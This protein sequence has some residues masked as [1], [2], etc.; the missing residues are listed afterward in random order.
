M[1]KKFGIIL[2]ILLC[3]ALVFTF[4][5][6]GN[7]GNTGNSGSNEDKNGDKPAI[8]GV[9]AAQVT[10]M[11]SSIS[12]YLDKWLL[13]N[14]QEQVK[15][16][17]DLLEAALNKVK[18]D[19][20]TFTDKDM[21]DITPTIQVSFNETTKK[22]TVVLSWNKNA[23][24]KTFEKEA[25]TVTYTNWA[26]KLNKTEGY[27]ALTEEGDTSGAIDKIVNAALSTVN[28][29]GTNAQTGKF[30][31]DGKV[32]LEVMGYNYMLHVKGNIDLKNAAETEIALLIE[33]TQKVLGGLYYKGAAESKDCKIILQYGETFK[34]LDYAA[35][36]R[37]LGRFIQ[38]K[39]AAGE[40]FLPTG[41]LAEVLAHY[42]VSP[43]VANTVASFIDMLAQGYVK[44]D[45]AAGTSTY[46]IDLNLSTVLS[47]V[48]E[49]VGDLVT[50]DMFEGIPVLSKLDISTMHGLLGH[51]TI[52]ATVKGA[53]KDV[54]TD[55]ELAVNL[56]ECTFYLNENE[57]DPEAK[58][59]IPSISFALYLKDFNF[60]TEGKVENVIPAAAANAEYFSPA[61]VTLS[62][63]IYINN[64]D[65]EI[66]DTFRFNLV[67]SVNPFNLSEAKASLTIKQSEG[68]TFNAESATNFFS[69]A[70]EHSDMKLC[71]SGTALDD[72]GTAIYVYN[73]ADGVGPIK[74]WLG[75]DNWQGIKYDENGVIT[76]KEGENAKPAMKALLDNKLAKAI[77][78]YYSSKKAENK[79]PADQPAAN[80]QVASAEGE[81]AGGFSMDNLGDYFGGL[82]AIYDDLVKS[83]VIVI[84]TETGSGSVEVT[85]AVINKVTASINALKMLPFELPT[86]IDQPEYVKGYFNT[87]G[88]EDK[89]YITVKVNGDVYELT[90]DGSKDNEFG[91]TFVMTT[92]TRIY[93][94]KAVGENKTQSGSF[95]VTYD[96]TDKAGVSK[97]HT[98]VTFSNFNANWGDSNANKL[99]LFTAEQKAAGAAIFAD[100]GVAT[101]LVKKLMNFLN[102]DAVEPVVENFGKWIVRTFLA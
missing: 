33:N 76:L 57:N 43:M 101:N 11:E 39:D 12:A 3:V 42:D 22:Y 30:G 89:L 17:A 59:D 77:L 96:V 53:N 34:Y 47:Q 86:D 69:V 32:G 24:K 84:D 70:Y 44:E 98:Q 64:S 58:F 25:K 1:K 14:A 50:P 28:K 18:E 6:C 13:A 23:I 61:N 63:D 2:A 26:G 80:G 56:P 87:K 48:A 79:K 15:D 72:V 102:K 19:Q 41:T 8:E 54:L 67:S 36:N 27:T 20:F 90:F 5:A 95:T 88:Y 7:K 91:V 99:E 71:V 92:E 21:N 16:Q 46:V 94:C 51:L 83:K 75:L 40:A 37:I 29:V 38:P 74:A 68:A 97:S 100:D 52:A 49:L 55:F 81:E 62:G 73:F 9:T 93:T 66:D 85:P 60:L 31:V 4:V 78:S 65:L 45:A 10:E 35:L 82:K